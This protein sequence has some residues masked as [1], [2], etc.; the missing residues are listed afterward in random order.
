MGLFEPDAMATGPGVPL[1][2]WTDT[3]ELCAIATVPSPV[4]SVGHAGAMRSSP[5]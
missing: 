2:T 4:Q 5:S 1:L 3:R